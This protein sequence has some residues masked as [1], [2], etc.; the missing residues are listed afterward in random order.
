MDIGSLLSTN[1]K[2]IYSYRR[3]P[4]EQTFLIVKPITDYFVI[5]YSFYQISIGHPIKPQYRDLLNQKVQPMP[6][7]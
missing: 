1:Q 5:F 4:K 7:E 2:D 6:C 3:F